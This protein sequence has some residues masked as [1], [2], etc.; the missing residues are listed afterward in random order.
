MTSSNGNIFR[1]TGHLSPV[2]SPHKGQ[3][4]G[5][6]MFSLI[7]IWINGWANNREAG[8]SR[9]YRAHYDVSVMH[10]QTG[11]M[12]TFFEFC[13]P[14]SNSSDPAARWN[15]VQQDKTS[16]FTFFQ[17]NEFGPSAGLGS[18]RVNLK[19]AF[20]TTGG[21]MWGRTGGLNPYPWGPT[22]LP[23]PIF[24]SLPPTHFFPPYHL[25]CA[26]YWWWMYQIVALSQQL[27]CFKCVRIP[28][29]HAVR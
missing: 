29:Q 20:Q 9:R 17:W 21:E 15:F 6:L 23:P 19:E 5:A 7:C 25:Y 4:Y 8:D 10:T 12:V 18:V 26:K 14:E 27:Y 1:V 28:K 2:N 11:L 22:P 24:S 13:T 3:W 16:N